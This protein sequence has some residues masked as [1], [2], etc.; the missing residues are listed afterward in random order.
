MTTV[1]V[2]YELQD[3]ISES[4]MNS[5]G[6][7]ANTYGLRRFRVGESGLHLTFEY[8]A[9]RLKP[10]EVIHVL[11]LAKIPIVGRINAPDSAIAQQ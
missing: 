2:T 1:E 8:D 3:P 5:L 9:S 11:R 6:A 10:T 4:Q 7:F